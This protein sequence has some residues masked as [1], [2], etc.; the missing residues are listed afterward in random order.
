MKKSIMEKMLRV[1]SK[2]ANKNAEK[3]ANQTCLWWIY[4]P[5]VPAKVKKMRK[6]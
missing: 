6:F 4:Q 3:S 1:I 5:E 2:A